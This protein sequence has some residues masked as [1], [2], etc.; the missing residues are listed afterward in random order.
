MTVMYQ[1][2]NIV[3]LHKDSDIREGT[4]GHSLKLF[5]DVLVQMLEKKASHLEFPDYGT[6][7]RK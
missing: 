2:S 5:I 1:V 7:Y 3:K 4:S 6:I